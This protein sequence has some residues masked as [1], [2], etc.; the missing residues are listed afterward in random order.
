[1]KL[2]DA[3]WAYST[4]YK[5]NLGMY[6]YRLVYGKSCHLPMELEHLAMWAIK[7][8]NFDLELAGANRKLQ[9]SKLEEMR[10]EA[11][12]SSRIY[13]A[14]AKVFLDKHILRKNFT[15]G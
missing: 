1:M 5:T 3:L 8:L 11:Y 12:K 6:Q 13:K 7:K 14:K 9:L 4:A 2:V 15:S 10:N